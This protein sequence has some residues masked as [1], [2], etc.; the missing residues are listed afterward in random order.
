MNKTIE[1]SLEEQIKIPLEKMIYHLLKDRPT[2]V[3]ILIN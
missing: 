3:V 1:Q 2:D